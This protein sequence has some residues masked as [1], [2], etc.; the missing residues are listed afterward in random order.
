[1][2]LVYRPALP[3]RSLET[4]SHTALSLLHAAFRKTDVCLVFTYHEKFNPGETAEIREGCE[5]GALGC[6]DCKKRCAA[7]ISEFLAPHIERRRVYEENPSLVE[8][9]LRDGETRGRAVAEE[10][11]EAVR[12]VMNL[13]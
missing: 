7:R 3:A 4:L 10:T 5:S 8:D 12:S 1:M 11:M 13:G 2:S 9:I 6:V